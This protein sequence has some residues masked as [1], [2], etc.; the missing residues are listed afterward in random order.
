M[1]MPMVA[2]KQAVSGVF[3]AALIISILVVNLLSTMLSPGQHFIPFAPMLMIN[4]RKYVDIWNV[5]Q[6]T[7]DWKPCKWWK[8]K[9]LTPLPEKSNGYIKVECYGGLNQMQRDLCD[10]IGIDHLLNATFVLPNFEIA[11]YWNDTSG[12]ADI[13]DV[14]YFIQ[15]MEGFVHVV[16][17]LP[18]DLAGR[19]PV[20][21]ECHKWKGHFDY[22]ESILPAFLDHIFIDIT[23]VMSQRSDRYPIYAKVVHCFT[24]G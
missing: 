15:Q 7:M 4:R 20:R 18:E 3:L 5:E 21:V 8:S 24:L 12:F 9:P 6:R 13:F 19:K 11:A 10:G 22:V 17:E 23:P 2:L 16:K 1:P 14:D